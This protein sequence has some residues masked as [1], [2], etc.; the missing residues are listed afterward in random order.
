MKK[1]Q[2]RPGRTRD[3]A[4][5]PQRGGGGRP[6]PGLAL[7]AGMLAAVGLLAVAPG[8]PAR[9]GDAKVAGTPY[10]ATGEVRCAA[11]T[12]AW[13]MCAFGVIRGGPGNA[14]VHLTAPDGTTRVLR[15]A[16]EH[17]TLALPPRLPVQAGRQGDEWSVT[18]GAGERYSIPVA[19][20]D[21][22]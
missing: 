9:A 19:V 22:G 5:W 3:G 2:G 6:S 8:A 13:S 17:V 4:A 12:A 14:E 10:H 18:L 16:G 15:F 20:I 1:P 21:G 7:A 11:G